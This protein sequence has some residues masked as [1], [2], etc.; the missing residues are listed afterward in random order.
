MKRGNEDS[1]EDRMRKIRYI[2]VCTHTHNHRDYKME[3]IIHLLPVVDCSSFQL[4]R[5]A[6]KAFLLYTIHLLSSDKD[7]SRFCSTI[8]L[9]RNLFKNL[10][11]STKKMWYGAGLCTRR[12]LMSHFTIHAGLLLYQCCLHMNRIV[13]V[14]S[15]G[16]CKNSNDWPWIFCTYSHTIHNIIFNY[17]LAIIGYFNI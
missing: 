4:I 2:C 11:N 15:R 17:P 5:R 8:N 12:V 3:S 6:N 10:F 1:I 14:I 9:N 7:T 16:R 13:Y